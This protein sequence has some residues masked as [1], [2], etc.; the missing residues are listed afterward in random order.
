[1][2]ARRWVMVACV[3]GLVASACSSSG[4]ADVAAPAGSVAAATTTPD[5]DET[6]PETTAPEDAVPATTEAPATS[7]PPAISAVTSAPATTP[8]TTVAPG[9]RD[10]SEIRPVVEDFVA[11]EGLNGA[12]LVIVDRDDGIVHEEY[13]GEF[14]ADRVSLI[15]SSSKMITAGVLLNLADR[16]LLD[17]DAPVADA[18][19][20]GAGNP[21]ITPAQLVSSSSGLVGLGPNAGYPPYICQFQPGEDL[22]ECGSAVF[23]TADDD[24][25]VVAPDTEFRY[26]G[27]QWQVAG[28][29]AE[30]VSGSTWSELI[31]E[32]YV[33]PCGVESLGYNNHW[34]Q[35]GGFTYPADLDPTELAPTD[36][37]NM[38]G[39]AF[40]TP[41]DYAALLL[42]HL[43]GGT[44]PNGRVLSDAAVER[45]HTDHVAATYADPERFPGYGFGWWIDR[46]TGI[47][48]DGGAYG[49]LPW[50]DLDD[51]YGAYLVIEASSDL[52]SALFRELEPL[53]DAAMTG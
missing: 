30:A 6:T 19:D 23:Q 51:G 37:P 27:A 26:G 10:F 48:S 28:A 7:E 44:C 36:N 53:V 14:S 12:G 9:G 33:E 16:G 1:M 38:E 4:T 45:S 29:L 2:R 15:A 47:L 39:G 13:V 35:A 46:E 52:G 22:Q 21:D 11:A 42:M 49:S 20:W 41:T 31:E 3:A 34:I 24:G 18:V 50:L 25:D 43:R 5:V 17:L 8:P 32:I 40:I